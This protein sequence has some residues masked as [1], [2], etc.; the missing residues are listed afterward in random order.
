MK[1]Q[2]A[3]SSSA[4]RGGAA[5]LSVKE[6]DKAALISVAR[7]LRDLG[8]DLIATHGTAK[9]LLAADLPVE[10]VSKVKEG[11]PHC[12]DRILSGDVQLVVNTTE[13]ARAISDSKSIRR[14]A[15]TRG[16]AYF[17][18]LRAAQ[19]AA[20][21]TRSPGRRHRAGGAPERLLRDGGTRRPITMA[22]QRFPMTPKG[23]DKMR[24]DLRRFREVER[25]QNVRDIEEALG[26]GDLSENAEY[27]AAKE[28]QAFIAAKIN[29]LE[30][31]LAL[32]QVIDPSELSRR[33]RRLRRHGEALRPRDR[34]RGHLH[35]RG[36]GRGRHQVRTH[37]RHAP[38]ARGLIGK[39]AG[40]EVRIRTP[41]GE[42]ELEVV[43]VEF[44]PY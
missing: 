33:D 44:K 39:V 16:V 38:I 28:K 8:F 18:T 3:A 7:E 24:E 26:H 36:R 9:A 22:E 42:R 13:G 20:T 2:L 31:K 34:R 19:A 17:T 35:D 6:S 41:K 10:T 23:R 21:G 37:R 11:R 32:S 14:A 25:P 30:A 15:V 29:E 43:D 27:S 5:F 12:V 4:P 40:D 1:S